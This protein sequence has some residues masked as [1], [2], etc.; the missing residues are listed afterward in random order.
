MIEKFNKKMDKDDYDK[1]IEDTTK[2]LLA[3]LEQMGT[4]RNCLIYF[5]GENG[6][7]QC[8]MGGQTEAVFALCE[9]TKEV[10]KVTGIKLEKLL[11][12]V[13]LSVSLKDCLS[14]IEENEDK[15]EETGN[16]EEETENEKNRSPYKRIRGNK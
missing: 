7:A 12:I 9:M 13:E 6:K 1:T 5:E 16:E 10:S 8:C 11:K 3:G 15:Q 14:E 4:I 2:K